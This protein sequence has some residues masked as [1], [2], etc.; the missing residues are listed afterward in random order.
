MKFKFLPTI[1]SVKNSKFFPNP[2]HALVLPLAPHAKILLEF[3]LGVVREHG[4][5]RENHTT[6]KYPSSVAKLNH[7]PLHHVIGTNHTGIKFSNSNNRQTLCENIIWSKTLFEYL[8]L[9]IFLEA[10]HWTDA[11]TQK[12][13]NTKTQ[14]CVFMFLET[15]Q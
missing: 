7:Q 1:I 6:S 10:L 9:S 3:N 5:Q 14:I 12:H 8:C 11:H 15:L 4:T 2:P 13:N